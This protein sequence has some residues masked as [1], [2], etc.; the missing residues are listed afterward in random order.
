[1]LVVVVEAD[2]VVVEQG[3]VAP[4][5]TGVDAELPAE[6]VAVTLSGGVPPPESNVFV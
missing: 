5:W 6:S 3:E 1:V 4:P 2:V